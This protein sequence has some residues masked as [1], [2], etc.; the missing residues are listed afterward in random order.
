MNVLQNLS[1]KT[2][3]GIGYVVLT[4]ALVLVAIMGIRGES[5]TQESLDNQVNHLNVVK[6]LGNRVLDAANARAV[7]ARNL[8]IAGSK[9]DADAETR[10]IGVAHDN[11]GRALKGVEEALQAAPP[12]T[13]PLRPLL[14][15]TKDTEAAYG[16]IALEITRLGSQG[17]KDV[18]IQKINAECRPLLTK[19]VGN[20]EAFLAES[21]AI[22]KRA[23]EQSMRQFE[24]LRLQL[25][26]LSVA[27]VVFACVLGMATTRSIVRPLGEANHA[28]REFAQ[29]N[30]TTPL[31]ARGKDEIAAVV[32]SMEA[33]RLSL[34]SLVAGVRQGSESV[35]TASAEIAQGN[36]NLSMRTEQQASALQQ[37]AASME[38]LGSTV[39]QN[40]DNA[41][42]A[43]RLAHSASTIAQQGG[44]VVALVVATMK[45]INESSRKI[46]DIISVIDGIAFQTNI[47]ALN[48]A[49]EAA[50]AGD[51]GRGF[52]VVASEV[53]NLA[54]RSAAAAK[55]IKHLITESVGRVEHGTALVDKAGH[56]MTEV[57][58]SIRNVTHI[59]GEISAASSEQSSGVTQVGEAVTLMDQAT[60]QN[61]AL[62]EEMA[63]AASSLR[64]QADDL[65]S[66]VAVFRINGSGP[67]LL[68]K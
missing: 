38:Q 42:N 18:A 56:T 32:A 51:Q 33:M 39:K 43:N 14:A 17:E 11:M 67:A 68:L 12:E 52:A 25:V 2:R 62:V 6:S 22:S 29:G 20:I 28:T 34:S 40:A 46:N 41:V 53:R 58:T 1:I 60:Q 19:L 49:V 16:P 31:V 63:A 24:S 37:T 55:E 27:M 35:S 4:C 10:R 65:V 30:L 47:L 48:A 8:V 15:Q 36:H 26:L 7:A 23:S 66:A 13:A 44:D 50:R 57:V 64:G 61:A 45:D 5:L 3:L 9:E 59:M 54:Q 21:D